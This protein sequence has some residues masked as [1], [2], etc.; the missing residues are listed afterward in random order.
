MIWILTLNTETFRN[1]GLTSLKKVRSTVILANAGIQNHL[2]LLDPG[3]RR[4]DA[5]H[6]FST[7]YDF[8]KGLNRKSHF[9]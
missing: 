2:I 5:Q 4:D 7:F 9:Q 1:Q 6:H 8:I 3:V